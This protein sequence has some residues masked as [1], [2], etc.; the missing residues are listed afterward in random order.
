MRKGLELLERSTVSGQLPSKNQKLL[1]PS[2]LCPLPSAL[3]PLPS[4]LCPLPSAFKNP[5]KEANG[6][7]CQNRG[8]AVSSNSK[9]VLIVN[10]QS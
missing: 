5:R 2:A 10:E 3:C 6:N 1:L 4:A 8:K 7:P 9:R